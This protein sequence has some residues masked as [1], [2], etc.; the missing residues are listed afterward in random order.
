MNENNKKIL[1]LRKTLP[2][3]RVST[4]PVFLKLWSDNNLTSR[5]KTEKMD[6]NFYFTNKFGTNQMHFSSLG[7]GESGPE[8]IKSTEYNY[9]MM[10]EATEFTEHD[11]RILKLR[12][13]AQ[14]L[15][16]LRNQLFMCFNPISAFHFIKTEICDKAN[17]EDADEIISNYKDNPFLP[18]D[19]TDELEKLQ[20]QNQNYYNI[21]T[22]GNWGVLAEIIYEKAWPQIDILP[23]TDDVC[24]GLD[25]GFNNPSALLKIA[26]KDQ[27]PFLEQLLYQSHLTNSQLIEQLKILI[28]EKDRDK[29]IFCDSAEPARIKEICDAGFNAKPSDKSVKDGI[30]Y[31]KSLEI[32][33]TS[34]SPDLIKEK[35][36]YSYRKDKDGRVLDDPIAFNDHLLSAARYALFTRHVVQEPRIR[37]LKS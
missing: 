9:I 10:E 31:L 37:W 5:I 18:K 2:S 19:Y 30:D 27:N 6:L 12:L 21:Y 14:S 22:L 33:V 8:K 29:D 23:E 16:G 4:L 35:N 28:P 36:S 13:S 24:Y 20:F 32:S 15:D 25:F 11:Y 1:V 3:L 7:P 34:N 17:L 26:T